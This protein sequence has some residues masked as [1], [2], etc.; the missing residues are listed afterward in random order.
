MKIGYHASHEQFAPA[1]LLDYVIAAERAGFEAAMCSEHIFPWSDAQGE[2]GFAW[3]WLGAAMQATSLPFGLVTAP[4]YR[5]HPTT[6][7][8][9][10]ATL[11]QMFPGRCWVALGSGEALNE[12]VTGEPWPRKQDRNERLKECGE[13]IRRLWAGEWVTHRGHVTVVDARLYSLPHDPP[14]MYVAAITPQTAEWAGGWADGIITVSRERKEM[15]EVIDSFRHGGGEGK[16]ILLQVKVSWSPEG[17]KAAMEGA[18]EQWGTN[19]FPSAI[20]AD[21]TLPDQFE[22]LAQY[23]PD[24][25]L[26]S[27]IRIS[28]DLDV[29]TELLR[30]DIA[31]GF[32]EIYIHNVNTNQ[33][34]F[35]EAFG[36]RVLPALKR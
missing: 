7:A 31:M 15:Q 23:V 32:S 20:A 1:E 35:I 14:G 19:V 18:R 4:G 36:S 12:H 21:L 24:E 25:R 11:Q 17:K 6:T 10:A 27:A 16:P 5:Y 30:E 33:R 29:H 2:S 13:I 9:A 22:K 26:E 34:E 3:S 28:P 8:H